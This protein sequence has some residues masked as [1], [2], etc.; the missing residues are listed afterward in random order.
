M[1]FSSPENV[2]KMFDSVVK[3]NLIPYSFPKLHTGKKWYVDFTCYDPLTQTMR[4]KKYHLDSIKRIS[5]RRRRAA[6]LIAILAL[7]LREGWTPWANTMSTRQTES[8]QY[9]VD[10]YTTYINMLHERKIMKDKTFVDYSS[11]LKMLRSY[12]EHRH[13]PIVYAYQFDR[14]FFSDFLDH[15][16]LDRDASARTRNNYRTWLSAFCSWLI[17]KKYMDKNPIED[18]KV[19]R[20]EPKKRSALSVQDLHRLRAHLEERNPN[21]LLACMMEYYTFIRPDELTGIKIQDI[22][23]QEQ[24]IFVS[25]QISK[26]RRDGMVGL[27]KGLILKMVELGVFKSP[28]NYYLFGRDFRPSQKKA[29]SR[30]FREEFLK[31]R[32]ALKWPDS[33]QF[34]SLKDSGIR[35]LA[36]AE[37]IVVARDQA[38]HTDIS[39][40]NKYL[41]ADLLSV[42][43]E[44]KKFEGNL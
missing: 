40:T 33:Y 26:N 12:N 23:L 43:E 30:I 14:G 1:R 24:K 10:H 18:I 20:E 37:G 11:R 6:E 41:K 31:V 13:E 34:Y 36:N 15:I 9:I 7:R 38:R 17:E 8:V 35:D 22:Y 29:D 16:M 32:K 44:T 28:G 4:R 2:K 27:N 21:Y 5:D 42:P 3:N 39:T 19:L 25:S